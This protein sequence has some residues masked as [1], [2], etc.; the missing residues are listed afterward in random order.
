MAKAKSEPEDLISQTEAAQ[1]R[2]VSPQSISELVKRGRLMK[3][4]RYG[5]PLVSRAEVLAFEP[6]THKA[7]TA[8][9]GKG[10]GK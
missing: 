9:K 10:K 4:V 8:K 2:G 5:L 1:L 3:Y 6:K 7:R